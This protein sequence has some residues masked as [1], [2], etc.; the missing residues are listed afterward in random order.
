MNGWLAA[1]GDRINPIVVKEVRQA[2]RG[3]L[4]RFGYGL[5]LAAA[6][7]ISMTVLMTDERN[8]PDQQL[9]PMLA[10][11]IFGCLLAACFAFIPFSAFMSMGGEW[12]ENTYDLL[13]LSNLSPR[14]IVYGKLIS[15]LVQSLVCFSAFTPF[16]VFA[17]LLRGI[18]LRNLL[19][20]LGAVLILSPC[21]SLIALGLSSVGGG[22]FQRVGLMVLLLIG[23]IFLTIFGMYLSSFALNPRLFGFRSES[24]IVVGV[25]VSIALAIGIYYGEIACARLCHPEENGSTGIRVA[26]LLAQIGVLIW[27]ASLFA[28]DPDPSLLS[29]FTCVALFGM[30]WPCAGFA[31]ESERLGRRVALHVPKSRLLAL[32]VA[33]FLPGG[34]RGMI[35]WFVA[36]AVMAAGLALAW[37]GFAA[38]PWTAAG[39]GRWSGAGLLS[40]AYAALFCTLYLAIPTRLFARRSAEPRMR[41]LARVCVVLFLVASIILPTLLAFILGGRRGEAFEH[42]LN[43]FWV[44]HETWDGHG[45]SAPLLIMVAP[46]ALLLTFAMNFGRMRAGVREVLEASRARREAERAKTPA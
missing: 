25:I 28:K 10:S 2:V 9:G 8:V 39:L 14:R 12:E 4:F 32:L 42:P 18:D 6:V 7:T 33:P 46:L 17:F 23:L 21:V 27:A 38:T 37:G 13:V 24:L 30:L 15:S 35:Y 5:T 11:S 26:V 41:R 16:F 31:S 43:P 1:L 20:M 34:G 22:R 29:A 3:R 45:S 44:L 36:N 19:L 40:I